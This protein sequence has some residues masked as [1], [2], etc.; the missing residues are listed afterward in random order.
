MRENIFLALVTVIMLVLFFPPAPAVAQENIVALELGGSSLDAQAATVGY[1]RRM[2]TWDGVG[3]F[4]GV[5]HPVGSLTGARL[6]GDLNL[7]GLD[8]QFTDVERGLLAP[9]LRLQVHPLLSFSGT[10]GGVCVVHA[11][12]CDGYAYAR[13]TADVSLP[14]LWVPITVKVGREGLLGDGA[15]NGKWLRS[16]SVG[17]AVGW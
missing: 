12:A 8:W 4:G 1:S 5:S 9:H 10:F 6:D 7:S 17:T 11:M 16:I 3:L 13:V 15:L 2:W 14:I